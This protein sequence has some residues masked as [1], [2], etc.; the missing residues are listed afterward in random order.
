MYTYT[1]LVSV[2]IASSGAPTAGEVYTLE[3]SVSGT[4]ERA[5]FQWLG[6]PDRRT[7]VIGSR[8]RVITGNSSVIR[9]Q[10]NP[11]KH[12]DIGTYMCITEISGTTHSK[13]VHVAVNGTA[14]L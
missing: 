9:L 3:C 14:V 1:L 13:S 10:F 11:L 12:T 2:A 7:P 4:N 8:T 6:P 5:T